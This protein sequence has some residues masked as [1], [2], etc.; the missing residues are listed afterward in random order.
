MRMGSIGNW[1]L[2]Y[3]AQGVYG[4]IV[5]LTMSTRWVSYGRGG[6]LNQR[7]ILCNIVPTRQRKP[8]VMPEL[9]QIVPGVSVRS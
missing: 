2:F 9:P 8:I 5:S 7:D 6:W 3:R 4:L 1:S